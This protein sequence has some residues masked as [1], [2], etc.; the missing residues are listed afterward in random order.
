MQAL[1]SVASRFLETLPEVDNDTR[2]NIAYH[3]AFAHEEV[4]A[5]SRMYAWSLLLLAFDNTGSCT[6]AACLR[7]LLPELLHV[8]CWAQ[9]R[10]CM[11]CR[12]LETTGRYNYTTPK[13]YLELIALYKSLLARKREELR[14][15][16]L[17][18]ENGVEK[19]AQASAQ[20]RTPCYGSLPACRLITIA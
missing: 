3:M 13:S 20:V 10:R 5:A 7:T 15:D 19:I 4:A 17:R 2:E 12:Y 9:T 18:L 1:V 11:V 16:K 14:A 6:S 8:H